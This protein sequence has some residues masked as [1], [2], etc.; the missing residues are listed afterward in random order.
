[1]KGNLLLAS[2][3]AVGVGASLFWGGAR[4]AEPTG[5][6]GLIALEPDE[7]GSLVYSLPLVYGSFADVEI[8]NRAD[9]VGEIAVSL[10]DERGALVERRVGQ[11]PFRKPIRAAEL[12]QVGN[13]FELAR[14]ASLVIET[15]LPSTLIHFRRE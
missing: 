13:L 1:M 2:A 10:Y 4:A 11:L 5:S 12:L 7:P 15:S 3:L 8:L 14:P 9:R 6:I